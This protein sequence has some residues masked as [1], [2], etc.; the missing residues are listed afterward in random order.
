MTRTLRKLVTNALLASAMSACMALS[1]EQANA[2]TGYTQ[3]T[4]P[5]V[6]AHGLL[7][8]KT[9][10]GVLDYWYEIPSALTSSGATVYVTQVTAVQSS[11]VRGEQ[12][13]SQIQTILAATGAKKVNLI[14]HSQGGID[15]RYVAAVRPDLVAS[16]TTVATPHKG[17]ALADYLGSLPPSEQQ[18]DAALF[19]AI[20]QLIDSAAGGSPSVQDAW[21]AMQSLST[22]GATAFNTSYPQGVPT[23][24]CGS[25]APSGNGILFYSWGGTGIATNA[26]D[27]SD[28]V[29]DLTSKVYNG[30][31]DGLVGQCSSHFGT[32]IRDNYNMNHLDEVNQVA[33]L[34]SPFETSPLTLFRAQANRLK[35]AGL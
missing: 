17:A 29:L 32:V 16:V 11:E 25:G 12:L 35:G 21:G 8:F 28:L 27:I 24:A 26:L 19:N 4:Y 7:G 15:A 20:G 22:A 33:G 1:A 2:A 23:T 5:I 3:T 18:L 31:N 34:V 6:L 9:L 30:P 10:L 13:L 14:G